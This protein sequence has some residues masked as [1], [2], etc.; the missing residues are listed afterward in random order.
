[1]RLIE[2]VLRDIRKYQWKEVA[3]VVMISDSVGRQSLIKEV[4]RMNMW[5]LGDVFHRAQL[6]GG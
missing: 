1:M 2:T 5:K 3:M 4:G 6:K